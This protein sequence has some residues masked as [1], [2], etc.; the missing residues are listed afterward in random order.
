M[1]GARPIAAITGVLADCEGAE[2]AG[3]DAD[4][5]AEAGGPSAS[6]CDVAFAKSLAGSVVE[7]V[8]DLDVDDNDDDGVPI[9]PKPE[10]TDVEEVVAAP[11]AGFGPP[12]APATVPPPMNPNPDVLLSSFGESDSAAAVPGVDDKK[13]KEEGVA[14]P[15]VADDPVVPFTDRPPNM[16]P[17]TLLFDDAAGVLADPPMLRPSRSSPPEASGKGVVLALLD[18]CVGR[19]KNPP[20]L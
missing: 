16:L 18:P 10:E 15:G 4:A 5:E 8:V 3:I 6:P 1:I 17:P 19:S 9:N 2:A 13:P 20:P 12:S 11:P 14:V 7:F